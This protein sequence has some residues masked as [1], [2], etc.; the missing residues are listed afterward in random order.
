MRQPRRGKRLG[1]VIVAAIGL[2]VSAQAT[3]ARLQNADYIGSGV[4]ERKMHVE[5][6]VKERRGKD[7]IFIEAGRIPLFCDDS[8]ERLRSPRPFPAK[9]D[10]RGH[11]ERVNY[12]GGGRDPDQSMYWY[13]GR[14]ISDTRAKGF[15][16]QW[17]DP[18]D[19]PD[20]PNEPECSTF[21]KVRWTATG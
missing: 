12:F 21:G 15:V 19:P 14:L 16:F 11:F 6:K 17:E 10:E 13:G 18:A 8:T 5:L 20:G 4:A 3:Q 1:L 2:A 7:T 9:L